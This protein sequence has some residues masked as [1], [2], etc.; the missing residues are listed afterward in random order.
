MLEKT[1]PTI[2]AGFFPPEMAGHFE[3]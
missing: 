1:S 2:L 3:K